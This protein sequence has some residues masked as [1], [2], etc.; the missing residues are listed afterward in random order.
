MRMRAVPAVVLSALVLMIAPVHAEKQLKMST[1]TS[2]QNSGLLEALLPP[3]EKANNVK[4]AVLAVGTGKALKLGENG[5]VD[6]VF[7]HARAAEDKFVAAGYGVDRKD[8][9]HND[10][11]IVGPKS[12]P[13]K[14]KEAKSAAEA[15]KRISEGKAPFVSRGDD[16]GTDKKEKAVWKAAGIKPEGTWYLQAGQGMG[17]VL[18]MASEK[19]G[20][21][22]SDRGTYIA[23]EDKIDL[24]IL[25]EGDKVLFNPYGI[26]AVNPK[27]H[28]AVQYELAKKFIDYVTGPEGQRII[29]NYKKKGKQLFY[30]DAVKTP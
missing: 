19:Q 29:N 22:L 13:A 4:V 2:T 11:V 25:L 30:S 21:T 8:V 7:V 20:Y 12:D 5:D 23:Y 1:T 10:F 18:L 28:P 14:V 16:S 26:I 27:K 24:P 15:L 6:V 9:M 3:F 17:P